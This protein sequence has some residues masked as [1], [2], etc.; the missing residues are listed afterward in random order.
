MHGRRIASRHTVFKQTNPTPPR[1]EPNPAHARTYEHARSTHAFRWTHTPLLRATY[2]RR[3]KTDTATHLHNERVPACR[4]LVRVPEAALA[5]PSPQRHVLRPHHQRVWEGAPELPRHRVRVRRGHHQPA[6]VRAG[7]HGH[8]CHCGRVGNGLLLG[9]EVRQCGGAVH[10][11]ARD[12]QVHAVGVR[13]GKPCQGSLGPGGSV[14]HAGGGRVRRVCV[15]VVVGGGAGQQALADDGH[16]G[17]KDTLTPLRSGCK[18]SA[19]GPRKQRTTASPLSWS[20]VR[21][22]LSKADSSPSSPPTRNVTVVLVLWPD[23]TTPTARPIANK[24]PRLATPPTGHTAP[25]TLSRP[26]SGVDAALCTCECVRV[27]GREGP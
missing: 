12:A 10:A 3:S 26:C 21:L 5:Q 25:G 2:A 20:K 13:G 18:R 16:G 7:P 23:A 11:Q 15:R 6:H 19:Q 27:W 17:G 9:Q 14:G 22:T 4:R 8:H 24:C 1:N